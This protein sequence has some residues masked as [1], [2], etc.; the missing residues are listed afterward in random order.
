MAQTEPLADRIGKS[1]SPDSASTNGGKLGKNVVEEFGAIQMELLE[2][3]LEAN[4]KWFDRMQ[5][6]VDLASEFTN[7]LATGGALPNSVDVLQEWTKRRLELVAEDA[8]IVL[9]GPLKLVDSGKRLL[10]DTRK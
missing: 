3:L 4:R 8:K 5:L 1:S 7:K 10:S 9:G 2:K 6:E